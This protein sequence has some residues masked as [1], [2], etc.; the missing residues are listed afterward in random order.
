MRFMGRHFWPF[1]VDSH[2]RPGAMYISGDPVLH[3]FFIVLRG[4]DQR[5]LFNGVQF[6]S[7]STVSGLTPMTHVWRIQRAMR[8]WLRRR[9]EKRALA[10]MMAWHVRLGGASALVTLPC[11]VMRQNI[12][13]HV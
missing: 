6:Y 11:D 5:N 1:L 9:W 7:C 4:L 10:I 8:G 12:L 3:A 2:S 13:L